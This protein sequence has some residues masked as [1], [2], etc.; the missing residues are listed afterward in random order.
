MMIWGRSGTKL[1]ADVVEEAHSW[2][3]DLGQ[4]DAR[5]WKISGGFG[6]GVAEQSFVELFKP[7]AAGSVRATFRVDGPSS[8]NCTATEGGSGGGFQ[9]RKCRRTAV[10]TDEG[11]RT[12]LFSI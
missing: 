6:T 11:V 4:G 12:P 10:S 1:D 8:T 9:V 2:L 3:S 7:S 5:R